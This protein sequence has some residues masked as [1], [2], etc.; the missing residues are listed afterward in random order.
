MPLSDRATREARYFLLSQCL[1]KISQEKT[2]WEYGFDHRSLAAAVDEQS[3]SQNSN[4]EHHV[5]RPVKNR[6]KRSS[7]QSLSLPVT[8]QMG[9][10]IDWCHH[11]ITGTFDDAVGLLLQSIHPILGISHL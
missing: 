9:Q 3:Q 11:H 10:H 8:F 5:E 2:S 1:Q 6:S 4:E 7:L